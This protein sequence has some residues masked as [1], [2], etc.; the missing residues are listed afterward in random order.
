MNKEPPDRIL[1]GSCH[2]LPLL[3]TTDGSSSTYPEESPTRTLWDTISS[4]N[5][6]AFVWGGDAIY[7][8]D[9]FHEATPSRLQEH[10]AHLLRYPG[11]A[12][13]LRNE[14]VILGVLDDHDYGV[15]NGDRTYKYRKESGQAFMDFLRKSTTAVDW[16]IMEKRVAENKGAYG[17]KA[18]DFDQERGYKVLSDEEAAIEPSISNSEK[19]QLSAKS[20]AIFLLDCRTNK[21]PWPHNSPKRYLADFEGDFLGDEQWAWLEAALSRSTAKVNIVVQGLQVHA[22]R[23]FG[24]DTVESWSS[25]PMAQH[26]LYQAILK[27]NV[28]SPFLV[29]GDVHMAQLLRRDC[30]KQ[31]QSDQLAS[32]IEVTTSGL[33]HAWC[34]KKF[35]ARASSLTPLFRWSWLRHALC[36]G[37]HTAQLFMNDVVIDDKSNEGAKRGRQYSLDINFAEFEFDWDS[38]EVTIRILGETVASAPALSTRWKFQESLPSSRRSSDFD[39]RYQRLKQHGAK[40]DDWVCVSYNGEPSGL[41][42]IIGAIVPISL[43]LTLMLFPLVVPAV[44][45]YYILCPRRPRTN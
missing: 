29:S 12:Q 43:V 20:V 31:D 9:S 22:D 16:A 4:R 40:P 5:A 25:F 11:Y 30:R 33:T 36:S 38:E 19:R 14:L 32:I 17:V 21:T 10:Y 1:F 23:F 6:S 37:M 35:W 7:G 8:D 3:S 45:A 34:A 41:H 27:S 18:I 42:K 13:Q 39:Q 2:S 44:V 28:S 26:R 24:G 15:N